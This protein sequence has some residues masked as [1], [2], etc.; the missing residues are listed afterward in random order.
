[1]EASA[2]QTAMVHALS[3]NIFTVSWLELK[4]E[5]QPL[6]Y[7]LVTW[8]FVEHSLPANITMH[9]ARSMPVSMA[10]CQCLQGMQILT[11]SLVDGRPCLSFRAISMVGETQ[12][13]TD[14]YRENLKCLQ[15]QCVDS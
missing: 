12:H 14:Q 7:T 11:M 2:K 3:H 10:S 1:M 8:L 5:T 13:I 4:L 15:L 6:R 9:L